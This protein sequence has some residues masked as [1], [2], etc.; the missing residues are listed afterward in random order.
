MNEQDPN[1][2][3]THRH[4][5]PKPFEMAFGDSENIEAISQHIEKWIGKPDN[6]FH[7]LISDKVHIDVHIVNPSDKFPFYTLVTSGMSDMPMH[8][9]EE[10]ADLAYAELFICLPADWKMHQDDW[11][12]E[13]YY[14]P[15]QALKYLAR[16]PHQHE[17]WLWYGH[18]IPNGDPPEPFNS[19][20]KLSSFVLLGPNCVPEEFH[21]L[22]ISEEKTIHFFA[23][24]PLYKEEL[25]LKLRSGAE[26]V[27]NALLA[28]GYSEL[29]DPNRKSVAP[30][31][32]G[33]FGRLFGGGR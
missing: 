6:V 18:T 12:S 11:K 21:E 24:V 5:E 17:T 9:P 20:T 13:R 19:S 22:K 1:V 2:G 32:P 30:Q 15:I 28:A 29:L 23:I 8:P 4:G 25:E 14:W 10:Y 3:P 7:E 16:F 31:R 26:E 33:F 27:E